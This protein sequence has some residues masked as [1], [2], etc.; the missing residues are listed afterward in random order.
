MASVRTDALGCPTPVHDSTST[1]P[2]M[3]TIFATGPVAA[4]GSVTTGL[5]ALCV[6][7]VT[8]ASSRR[9]SVC[10]SP[11]CITEG[12]AYSAAASTPT[13]LPFGDLRALLTY[14]KL[15]GSWLA[16]L[17][18]GVVTV[19]GGAQ[20]AGGLSLAIPYVLL[21]LLSFKITLTAWASSLVVLCVMTA[22]GLHSAGTSSTGGLVFLWLLPLQL[23]IACL[24][25]ILRSSAD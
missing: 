21:G 17:V 7:V 3:G 18:V 20:V 25:T 1:G 13:I 14:V 10:K 2:V 5:G 15:L 23:F 19:T 4:G 11:S 22:F 24:P 16:A 9:C 6:R 8:G 12:F